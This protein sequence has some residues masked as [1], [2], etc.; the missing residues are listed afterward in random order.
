[1]L[2]MV[3]PTVP[4]SQSICQHLKSS[5]S[6]S[7]VMAAEYV[8]TAGAAYEQ[9]CPTYVALGLI[10]VINDAAQLAGKWQY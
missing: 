6:W 9:D 1:M 5:V 8:A 2:A 10:G 7:I 4:D 3:S